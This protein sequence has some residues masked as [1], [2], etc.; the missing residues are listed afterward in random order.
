VKEH[1]QEII[2]DAIQR[3]NTLIAATSA[4]FITPFMASSINLAIPTIGKQFGAGAFQLGWVVTGYLLTSAAF[5]LP[6]GKLAD[7]IGRRRVFIT[8]ITLFSTLS[9]ICG[10]SRT[11][12]MLIAVRLL[13]GVAAAMIFGTS[14]A[15]LTS[16]FPASERGR[17]LGINSASVYVGLSLGPVLGGALNHQF[18]WQ[19]IFF[20]NTIIGIIALFFVRRLK[21]E[22]IGT[23]GEKYDFIGSLLYSAGLVSLMYGISSITNSVWAKMFIF[24]GGVL[25]GIFVVYDMGTEFP[26]FNIRLFIS[27]ATFT[28]SNLAALINFSATFAVGYLLSIYLQTVQGYDS[29]F[30]GI[31]LLAQPLIMAVVSPVAG[32]MYDRVQPRKIASAGMALTMVALLVFSQI[33]RQTSLYVLVFSLLL[34]GTGL[35]LFSSPNTNAVMGAVE[36]MYYGVASSTLGT[37]RLVGQAVS[38]AVV[39]L[40]MAVYLG[41]IELTAAPLDSLLTSMRILFYIFAALCFAGIFASLA[42]GNVTRLERKEKKI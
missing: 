26:L 32:R 6:F 14:I 35:A 10:F 33:S 17:V 34:F 20:A 41:D 37:M 15:I 1:K 24:M 12:E 25:L 5:L 38:M 36:R 27:N 13:Q 11:I 7:I 9:L 18:G 22:W 2:N 19:S 31:V 40:L 28:F 21:G 8:G 3:R 16:V 30:S 29:Q 39:T 42:R 4:A 23:P